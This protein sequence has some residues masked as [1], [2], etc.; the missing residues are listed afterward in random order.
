MS[1]FDLNSEFKY[2]W[3]VYLIELILK[4]LP[5]YCT[6]IWRNRFVN[7]CTEGLWIDNS[8]WANAH[9]HAFRCTVPLQKLG[10][11]PHQRQNE[12]LSC[13]KTYNRRLSKSDIAWPSTTTSLGQCEKCEWW[14]E[15][16]SGATEKHAALWR[17]QQNQMQRSLQDAAER[18]KSGVRSIEVGRSGM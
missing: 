17:K 8:S 14:G 10:M 4:L 7:L 18:G 13:K 5:S 3:F 16:S 15:W 6:F 2:P 9:G 12:G 1:D 11:G